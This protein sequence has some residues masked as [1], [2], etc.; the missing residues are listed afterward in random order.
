MV[1][2]NGPY[3]PPASE[4]SGAR[5]K[6]EPMEKFELTYAKSLLDIGLDRLSLYWRNPVAATIF[7]LMLCWVSYNYALDDHGEFHP[8]TFAIFLIVYTAILG[9]AGVFMTLLMC[10][11]TIWRGSAEAIKGPFR[12]EL[13]E[14]GVT[15]ETSTERLLIKWRGVYA[16]R[17]S[18][19]YIRIYQT[20]NSYFFIPR[21]SLVLEQDA[22]NF[23][24]TAKQYLKQYKLP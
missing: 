15:R 4:V 8:T 20:P 11:Y 22:E 2:Q 5:V 3:A 17:M 21:R 24:L 12:I 7:G 13:S 9:G 18:S 19:W 10:G 16:I 14:E 23:Y 6:P 1:A